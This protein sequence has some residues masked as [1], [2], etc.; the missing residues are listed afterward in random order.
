M[1]VA[2]RLRRAGPA[3]CSPKRSPR[4]I[5]VAESSVQRSSDLKRTGDHEFFGSASRLHSRH[6]SARRGFLSTSSDPAMGFASLRTS[7]PDQRD[8]HA[9]TTPRG[10]SA[11]GN[12]FRP[13]S[14][15]GFDDKATNEMNCWP[16]SM[17]AA[18]RIASIVRYT[19]TLAV[20]GTSV[21]RVA[22][23]L[24]LR[25]LCRSLQRVQGA[26][27]SPPRIGLRT[28]HRAGFLS[29]VSHRP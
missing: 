8:N 23:K 11:S 1:R 2:R 14:A 27:A 20:T 18:R 7:D 21:S 29:E 13:L 24:A 16:R 4:L 26:D 22:A 28:R 17:L 15:H 9:G 19:N 12:R 25:R 6:R 5:F 3:C 10:S